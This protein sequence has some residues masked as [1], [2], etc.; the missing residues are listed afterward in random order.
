MEAD[1]DTAMDLYGRD[2]AAHHTQH[3]TQQ[4]RQAEAYKTIESEKKDYEYFWN[5]RSVSGAS[6]DG[7]GWIA[8]SGHDQ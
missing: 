5:H 7:R 2:Y 8:G 4:S 6:P 1:M 3:V